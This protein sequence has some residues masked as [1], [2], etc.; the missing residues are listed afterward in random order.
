MENNENQDIYKDDSNLEKAGK[1]VAKKVGKES[2]KAAKKVMKELLK[3]IVMAIGVKTIAIVLVVILVIVL[4]ASFWWGIGNITFD[5]ISEMAKTYTEDGT[6]NIKNITDIDEDERKLKINSDEFIEQ[7]K[8]W[9]KNNNI[10]P[11]SLGFFDDDYSTFITFLQAEAV[12]SF[13]DLRE[14]SKIGT[15]VK[16]DE[17]Q[18]TVQFNRKYADGTEQLLEFK[19]YTEYRK[20]LA[21]FGVKLDEEETQ[22]QVYFD[23]ASVENA[24]NS[25]KTYF[26]LD[27]EYNLIIATLSSSERKVTHSSYAKEEGNSDEYDYNFT[28]DVTRINYQSVV[29]K[30]T[31]PFEFPLALLMITANPHFCEEVAKLAM[32]QEEGEETTEA[33]FTPK[34]VVDIQDNKTSIYVKED[35]G[36]TA[37][38]K[39][40]KYVKFK[41]VVK[42][43]KGNV[44]QELTGNQLEPYPITIEKVVSANSYRVTENWTDTTTSQLCVS[45]ANTWIADYTS[46]YNKVDE[47]TNNETTA[48]EGDDGDYREVSD[49]HGYLKEAQDN[50]SFSYSL[51]TSSSANI[52]YVEESSEY[53]IKE[54]DTGKK[55]DIS[56]TINTTKFEKSSSQVKEK[57]ERFLSLLKI[58]KEKEVFNLEDIKKNDTYI[59]YVIEDGLN[60]EISPEDNLLSAEVALYTLLGS[61]DRTVTFEELMR[62]LLDIYTGRKKASEIEFDFSI[63]E[64][65]EFISISGNYFGNNFEE[66][67]WFA[68]RAAGYDEYA[69]AG[70]MGNFKK[71]SGFKA[72]NVQNSCESRVGSDEVYTGKVNNGQYSR[73]QFISD[74]AGYGLAQWTSSGRKAGLYDLAKSKGVGIDNEDLQI[75]WL[76]KEMQSYGC[77]K[78]QPSIKEAT[79]NFHNVFEKSA[80]SSLTQREVYAQEIYDRYHGKTAPE[81]GLSGSTSKNG[82]KCPQY[83]QSDVRWANKPYNYKRGGTIKSGGCGACA[84]AMAVSGLTQ[85]SVTPDIIVDYLNSKR[86]NT[87]NGG[88]ICAQS[89]ATKYG[90]TYS[91]ISR[92]DKTSIDKALD[93]GKCLIFSI[94]ANGIYTGSGHFIMCYGRNGD[95]YYVLESA[96]YYTPDHGY[97]FNQVFTPGTQGVFILGR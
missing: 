69:T 29:Q 67:V 15:P 48:T 52:T 66:K 37:N 35:Y 70:A 88:A 10:E 4:L 55:T 54:K 9:F 65:D 86:I 64:P 42:D 94:K 84:L 27:E 7:L 72:N 43:N 41:T 74:S 92:R 26:T 18:G 89:I 8:Q 51:P 16:K 97:S 77:R 49:C 34:I 63:Y 71:E 73:Q 11:G 44:V 61:N 83:K 13:P 90:L 57:W 19:K 59:R 31:M 20:E 79:D 38:F 3:K 23:K 33:S 32:L 82:V 39:L 30:Y 78:V 36:Y 47:T 56:T 93:E 60:R 21:K 58:E 81:G 22:E 24:Y 1:E 12:S 75:E 40:E 45:E 85:N 95:K 25:L 96:S 76:L 14:R 91:Q 2:K 5:S 17:L 6:G 46:V 87:V 53:K 62:D 50:N 80:D 28:V 68:L